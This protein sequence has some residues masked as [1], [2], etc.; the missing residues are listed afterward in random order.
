MRPLI[1]RVWLYSA[2]GKGKHSLH[3][4]VGHSQ[5]MRNPKKEELVRVD[6]P[7]RDRGETESAILHRRYMTERPGSQGLFDAKGDVVDGAAL[8]AE[9]RRHTGPVWRVIVS[10]HE[11]DVIAMGG[12]LYHR[13][14]WEDA[15]RAVVPR[16]ADEMGIS[17]ASVRWAAAM[18]RKVG[19]EVTLAGKTPTCHVHILLWSQDPARGFLSREGIDASRRAWASLLYA[20]AR[21]I[22]EKEK[23]GIRREIV[24][25]SRVV[26]GRSAAEALGARLA[27]IAEELPGHGRVSYAFAPS[28]VK[29]K[30]DD[31][32]AWL[33]SQPELQSQA[34]RYGAI[35]AELA[36]HYSYRKAKHEEARQNALQDLRRRLATGI[37]RAS[38]GYDDRLAWQ[39]IS[40]EIWRAAR[41]QGDVDPV[42]S[43]AVREATSRIALRRS[44]A[45][46]ETRTL[47]AGALRPQAQVLIDRAA[48]RG[49]DEGRERRVQRAE[50]RLET[51]I[52]QRLERSAAY[53]ADARAYQ[54]SHIASG[55]ARA[56]YATVRQAEREAL[57]SAAREAEEEALRK[58]QAAAQAER[59]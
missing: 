10:V 2:A 11:D 28:S 49:A 12:N 55:L 58:R 57:L 32:A 44:D 51:L 54:A 40:T 1:M 46:T 45:V 42:L 52:V 16:M 50:K 59:W 18:H 30:L 20:P 56:M 23:S 4:A 5:Y 8:D 21:R 19:P 26:L 33:L 34:E 27:E 43:Q 9:I 39:Q 3:A 48:Q 22:L 29:T 14:A 41:G 17:A 31:T 6:E 38:L 25:R 53:V 35:A 36:S 15:V 13:A 24:E 7:D 37:L 47:L